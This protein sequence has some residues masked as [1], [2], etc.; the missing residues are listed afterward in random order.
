M[1]N[2]F[3]D[4]NFT[5]KCILKDVRKF[6]EGKEKTGSVIASN[7]KGCWDRAKEL[8]EMYIM[9]EGTENRRKLCAVGGDGVH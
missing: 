7:M 5:E 2:S 3:Y 8:L 4:D 9:A 6:C 1:E